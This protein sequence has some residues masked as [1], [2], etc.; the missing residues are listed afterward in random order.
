MRVADHATLDAG[1]LFSALL[2]LGCH[3]MARGWHA[4]LGGVAGGGR[5]AALT[6][7]SPTVYAAAASSRDT[8]MRLPKRV[9]HTPRKVRTPQNPRG[10]PLA[11]S[12]FFRYCVWHGVSKQESVCTLCSA[13]PPKHAPLASIRKPPRIA[14]K[15]KYNLS[16][17]ALCLAV[18][19]W[20]SLCPHPP[21][22]ARVGP[23]GG[24]G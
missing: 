15:V 18:A 14:D 8:E 20:S 4:Q 16:N 17:V 7:E 9:T 11:P 22:A 19:R 12:L 13:N 2:L 21:A 24:Q 3:G 5:A 1:V 23:V 6:R 10:S